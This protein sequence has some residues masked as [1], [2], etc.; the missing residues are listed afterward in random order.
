MLRRRLLTSEERH[1][2]RTAYLPCAWLWRLRCRRPHQPARP[3]PTRPSRTTYPLA[4]SVGRSTMINAYFGTP[5]GS[6][7][8][9]RRVN[10]LHCLSESHRTYT[11]VIASLIPRSGP[12]RRRA[13]PAPPLQACRCGRESQRGQ[14]GWRQARSPEPPPAVF[15]LRVHLS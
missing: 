1:A 11:E 8:N 10:I 13:S 4:R 7:V 3:D 14:S 12:H 2:A 15:R 9:L 6:V 5:Y